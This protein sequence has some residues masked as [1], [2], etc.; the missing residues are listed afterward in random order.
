MCC[1]AAADIIADSAASDAGDDASWDTRG[2][3]SGTANDLGGAVAVI[4]PD[5][6]GSSTDSA[7]ADASG[8]ANSD[9]IAS[10]A[11]GPSGSNGNTEALIAAG[12]S[13]CANTGSP[14]FGF[15]RLKELLKCGCKTLA[16]RLNAQLGFDGSALTG[17]LVNVS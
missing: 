4:M 12:R 15:K 17:E 2:S 7:I 16:P 1:G 14:A 8:A 10:C 13:G 3:P 6:L 5:D 9:A 11:T